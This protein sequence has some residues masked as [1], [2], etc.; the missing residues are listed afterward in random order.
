MQMS[1]PPEQA[2]QWCRTMNEL[3]LA[4]TAGGGLA[5]LTALACVH[6]WIYRTELGWRRGVAV[7]LSAVSL[8]AGAAAG[9]LAAWV[10]ALAAPSA[11][12]LAFG[13]AVVTSVVIDAP[14]AIYVARRLGLNDPRLRTVAWT[15][16]AGSRLAAIVA[17]PVGYY[18]GLVAVFAAG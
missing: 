18:A 15:A 3:A 16:A 17:L 5:M 12:W 4:C 14:L 11:R 9:I 6:V 8:S 7:R 10:V 1:M 13:A 2:E